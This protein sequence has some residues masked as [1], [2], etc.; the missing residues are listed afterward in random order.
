[1]KEGREGKKNTQRKSIFP[2]RRSGFPFLPVRAAS[3]SPAPD[4]TAAAW[5]R[6]V[7]PRCC[8]P[9][10][11][12]NARVVWA[13]LTPHNSGHCAREA[14]R[15][16]EQGRNYAVPQGPAFLSSCALLCRPLQEVLQE[17]TDH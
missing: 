9:R 15:P 7:F 5:G 11:G 12:V 13:G 1:M 6:R 8:W 2:I 14:R 10:L 3:G 4:V 16:R 17:P